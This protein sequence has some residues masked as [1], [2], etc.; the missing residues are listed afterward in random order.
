GI[1]GAVLATLRSISTRMVVFDT[2]VVDLSD[3]LQDPVD[4]LF[5]VQLGGGT[6]INRA[7][8]YCQ[9]VITRPAQTILVLITDLFEGGDAAELLK[10][11]AAIVRSG[12]SVICLLA[13]NDHGAP[14]FESRHAAALAGLGVPAFACTPDLFPDLMAAAVERRDLQSWTAAQGLH[15][16]APLPE[17]EVRAAARKPAAIA[18]SSIPSARLSTSARASCSCRPAATPSPD[19]RHSRARAAWACHSTDRS[20]ARLDVSSARSTS[21]TAG[22]TMDCR[23][24]HSPSTRAQ[25]ATPSAQPADSAAVSSAGTRRRAASISPRP[26]RTRAT[27]S[28]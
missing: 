4:L 26:R 27:A 13:L 7:L 20:P 5:G 8:A 19:S 3:D 2:E 23:A 10:R 21:S 11:T 28:A 18:G 12:T 17:L 15:T 6:D 16:A 24:A 1:F 14:A 9:Q 22:S 25:R